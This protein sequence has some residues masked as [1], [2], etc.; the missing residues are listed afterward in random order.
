MLSNC[1]DHVTP[2]QIVVQV[3]RGHTMNMKSSNLFLQPRMVGVR[4]LNVVDA[5]QHPDPLA[6][7]DRPVDHTPISR[8][9]RESH[10][11]LGKK[12]QKTT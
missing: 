2:A 6:Q 3:S 4:V 8:A 9:A 7:I 5:R 1:L 10:N 11:K 12:M